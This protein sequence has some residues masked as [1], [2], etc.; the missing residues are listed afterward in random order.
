ML[1]ENLAHACDEQVEVTI[2]VDIA[3]LDMDGPL[4]VFGDHDFF[5]GPVCQLA[6]PHHL[7]FFS[8]A[9]EDVPASILVEVD[10]GQVG[11][12]GYPVGGFADAHRFEQVYIDD[13]GQVELDRR[14]LGA[15]VF[16]ATA[17]EDEL[18]PR[19]QRRRTRRRNWGGGMKT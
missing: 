8:V 1:G 14:H 10:G 12:P 15:A 5:K 11:D 7:V 13:W 3:R 17:R 4:H 16:S 9:E 19:A 2:T 6:Q 18:R